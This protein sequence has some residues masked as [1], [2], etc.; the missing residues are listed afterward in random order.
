[1]ESLFF[2]RKGDHP[3]HPAT[4]TEAWG[5]LALGRVCSFSLRLL[6]PSCRLFSGLRKL[7]F[8]L[9]GCLPEFHFSFPLFLRGQ[10]ILDPGV[11][12]HSGPFW[13]VR[14]T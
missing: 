10:V 13:A 1:M 14:E 4:P 7:P 11:A 8:P 12:F 3:A 9:R 5:P 6:L 2:V